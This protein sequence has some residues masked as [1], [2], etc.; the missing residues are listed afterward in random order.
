M[1]KVVV[2]VARHRKDLA[3]YVAI[4]LLA[5]VVD[6]STLQF[7]D[8]TLH[9]LLFATTAG[10]LAGFAVSYSLNRLRFNRRHN[11]TRPWHQTLPLFTTL[12]IFNT[13]FTYLC[14]DYNDRHQIAPRL[15]VKVFT[16]GLMVTWNYILF[17]LF[18]FRSPQK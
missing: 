12:F 1:H 10:I 5:F 16:V 15:F 3:L 14:L 9:N 13:M 8:K 2:L 11:N 17:H 4:G 6:Y 7:T 18:I